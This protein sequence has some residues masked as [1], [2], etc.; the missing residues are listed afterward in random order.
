MKMK[1]KKAAF[2]KKKKKNNE[3]KRIRC[4]DVKDVNEKKT[5]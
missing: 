4:E 1:E 2:I 5:K 3:S